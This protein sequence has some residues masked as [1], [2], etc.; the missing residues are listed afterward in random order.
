[1]AGSDQK[2][3]VPHANERKRQA[4]YWIDIVP[5]TKQELTQTQKECA[6]QITVN[7]LIA[8]AV[9]PLHARCTRQTLSILTTSFRPGRW[10]RRESLR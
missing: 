1:M 5:D 8:C 10:K 6:I 3:N 2:A 9:L 7:D 4:L